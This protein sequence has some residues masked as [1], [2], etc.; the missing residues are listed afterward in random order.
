M[1][2]KTKKEK[3][4][5]TEPQQNT[6]AWSFVVHFIQQLSRVSCWLLLCFLSTSFGIWD[7]VRFTSHSQLGLLYQLIYVKYYF[8]SDIWAIRAPLEPICNI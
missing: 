6:S 2:H 1:D 5:T 7:E 8:S 4:N 3:I